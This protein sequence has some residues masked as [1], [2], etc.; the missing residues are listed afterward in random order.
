MVCRDVLLVLHRLT[1]NRSSLGRI[2]SQIH[3][4]PLISS[5]RNTNCCSG[6]GAFGESYG[7]TSASPSKYHSLAVHRAPIE[8]PS[9]RPSLRLSTGPTIEVPP[10]SSIPSDT[11]VHR[12]RRPNTILRLFT[13]PTIQL[14]S[15]RLSPRLSTGP[16]IKNQSP[17][18]DQLHGCAIGPRS[19]PTSL[20]QT[21]SAAVH[22][23]YNRNLILLLK[24]PSMT[25]R[26]VSR[27]ENP[28]GRRWDRNL[29][30]HEV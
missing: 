8:L 7:C 14:P 28:E 27:A 16:T 13:C 3:A 24:I 1:L 18:Q 30:Q 26:R 29:R 11:A 22:R 5:C 4:R 15:S 2:D 25:M 12:P 17:P 10:S 23:P 9:S 19:N 6:N 21:N 20:F